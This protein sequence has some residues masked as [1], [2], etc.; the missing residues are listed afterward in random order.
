LAKKQKLHNKKVFA[1][2]FSELQNYDLPK[3][4]EFYKIDEIAGTE[5]FH[6]LN[7]LF[8]IYLAIHLKKLRLAYVIV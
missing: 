8:I 3:L 4:E 2:F 5:V 6:F 7:I 1:C